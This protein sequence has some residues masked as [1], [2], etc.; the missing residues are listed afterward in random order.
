LKGFL[1]ALRSTILDFSGIL[2]IDFPARETIQVKFTV[3][4]SVKKL[5]KAGF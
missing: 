1:Q 3:A 2:P 5:Y 4:L